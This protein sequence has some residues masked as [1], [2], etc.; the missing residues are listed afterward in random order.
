MG[1]GGQREGAGRKPKNRVGPKK[2]IAVY[3]EHDLI[4]FCEQYS[5]TSELTKMINYGIR[6][7][8]A[9]HQLDE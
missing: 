2:Q 9:G 6:L 5:K 3:I 7:F 8:K 4:E 1:H